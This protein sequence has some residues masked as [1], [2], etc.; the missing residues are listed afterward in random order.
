MR[1][2]HHLRAIG[3]AVAL[4]AGL[5]AA[6]GCQS[7]PAVAPAPVP[8]ATSLFV[9]NFTGFDVAVYVVPKADQK[10]VWLTN[11]SIGSSRSVSIRWTDLQP[12][13]ALV[14]RTQI[15]GSSK[16]WTS[17]PLIIDDGIVGVL[18]IKPDRSLTTAGS[19]LRGVTLQAFSAAMR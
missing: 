14:V 18:D 16:T 1:Y 8:E 10:P 2:A 4:G 7:H 3:I 15:L 11:V 9:R 12:S 17:D 19:V 6:T 13:G 5:I